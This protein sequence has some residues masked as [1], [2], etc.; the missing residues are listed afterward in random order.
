MGRAPVSSNTRTVEERLT[1]LEERRFNGFSNQKWLDYLLLNKDSGAVTSDM[2]N[3]GMLH[4]IR[5]APDKIFL[6]RIAADGITYESVGVVMSNDTIPAA[7]LDLS[8]LTTGR[9]LKVV[10]GVLTAASA[11][12]APKVDVA[13]R[14]HTSG[15]ITSTTGTALSSL[16]GSVTLTTGYI[17]DLF[18]QGTIAANAP[19]GDFIFAGA[20]VDGDVFGYSDTGTVG[21]ERPLPFGGYKLGV[22]GDGAA[23]T[24][25]CYMK[26]GSGTGTVNAGFCEL[27]AIPRLV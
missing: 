1:A 25:S 6:S 15:N 9:F 27:I 19:A 2:T 3:R 11:V 24:A 10:A 26:V 20:I 16:Q 17:W 13:Y 14:T 8:A 22:T 23:H 12:I 7:S 18:F 21:G 4:V 5:G